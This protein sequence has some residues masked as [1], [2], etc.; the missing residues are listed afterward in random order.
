L[1][2][3]RRPTRNRIRPDVTSKRSTVFGHTGNFDGYTQFTAT[4]R[5]TRKSVTVSANR[6]LAPSAPAEYAPEAFE[7]LRRNYA[8]AV[9]ALLG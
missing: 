5:S 3:I 9:C 2:A 4:T 1:P 8:R 6:Q 7:K